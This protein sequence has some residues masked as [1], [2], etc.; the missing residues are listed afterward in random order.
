MLHHDTRTEISSFRSSKQG[1][2]VIHRASHMFS[3]DGIDT[4]MLT[5]MRQS[6]HCYRTASFIM[7]RDESASARSLMSYVSSTRQQP[8]FP[9]PGL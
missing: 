7:K 4:G 6:N 8:Q 5:S 9:V 2:K 1:I 3:C